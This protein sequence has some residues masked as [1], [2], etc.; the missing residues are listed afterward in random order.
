MQT[1]FAAHAL[2]ATTNRSLF[3]VTARQL[4]RIFSVHGSVQGVDVNGNGFAFVQ[5]AT[6]EEAQRACKAE[7][8]VMLYGK[9]I[10]NDQH[11]SR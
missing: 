7:N 1:C 3:A 11:L 2:D 10:G 8:G 4:E 6:P 5:F 9:K